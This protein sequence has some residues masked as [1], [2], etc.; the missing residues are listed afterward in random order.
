MDKDKDKVILNGK[1]TLELKNGDIYE[2]EFVNN[3]KRAR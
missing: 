3:V 2:G 1:H